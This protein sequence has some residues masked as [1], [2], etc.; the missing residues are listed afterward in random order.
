MQW[1]QQLYQTLAA[2]PR[3]YD[4]LPALALALKTW[5]DS[6][7]ARHRSLQLPQHLPD[8][9]L[10]VADL[11]QAVVLGQPGDLDASQ[12]RHLE[13]VLRQLMPWRKGPYQ[14]ADLSIDT[15]WRSDW[16]WERVLPHLQP[17]KDRLVLDVGA[18]NGYHLW[19]MHGAGGRL[20]LGIDPYPLF[21][22]QFR[23]LHHF[24]PLPQVQ[25]LPLG[26]DE[27]PL[28]PAFDTVFSMGVLYHRRDPLHFLQQLKS[29]LRKDGELVLETLVV[30]GDD[31]TVLMPA[32]RYARM[33]NVWMLPSVAALT[34]WLARTGF[35]DIR[36]VD[37]NTTTTAEQ[38]RT[39][40][41]NSESLAE[42][43]DPANPALTVEGYPAPCRAVLLARN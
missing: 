37:L 43:L 29:L 20:A 25:L 21:F 23:A 19:R 26:I 7:E 6:P 4:W 32:E 5:A 3:L 39:G 18:G 9:R 28:Q 30:P 38:R 35:A 8:C 10:A 36:L 33:R 11:Q 42:A 1:F 14:L 15:E 16:K 24:C 41:L 40:W 31:Q 17:L 34:R 2:E 13:L 27:L 22:A 12:R